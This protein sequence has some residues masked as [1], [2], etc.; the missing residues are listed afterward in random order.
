M[1]HYPLHICLF[2]WNFFFFCL[3]WA[4]FFIIMP[5]DLG[6]ITH[7]FSITEITELDRNSQIFLTMTQV[8]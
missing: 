4:L 5:A 1:L 2:M 3:Y 8:L 7:L 6:I